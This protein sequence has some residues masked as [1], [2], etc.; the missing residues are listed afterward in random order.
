[1]NIIGSKWIFRIKHNYDGSIQQYKARL[2]AQGFHQTLGIDFHETF[3][4]VIKPPTIRLILTLA[5]SHN[6]PVLQLD[7]NNAFLNGHLQEKVFMYQPQDFED[8]IHP[9]HVC[10]LHKALY[11]LK[12]T[13]CAWFDR[14]RLTLQQWG[15]INS[16]VDS[17][18]FYR[19]NSKIISIFIFVDDILVASNKLHFLTDFTAKLHKKFALKDL[20]PLYYF[21][22][23]Q[24]H[25]TPTG[26]YLNQAQY[27]LDLLSK[28]QM[29]QSAPCPTPIAIGNNLSKDDPDKLQ[30]PSL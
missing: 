22:G 23:I 6:W 9:S 29:Q 11:G 15:F 4:P 3:S 25:R 24:I 18:L 13:P 2:V 16:K 26:F 1:M 8:P 20:G 21:I 10:Q 17:F 5:A 30:E 14:L 27:T 12:Q 19:E 7:I 28:F